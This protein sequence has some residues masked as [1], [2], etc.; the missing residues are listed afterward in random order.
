MNALIAVSGRAAYLGRG[1][2]V[3]IKK[4]VQDICSA[5]GDE[6]CSLDVQYF[7]TQSRPSEALGLFKEGYNNGVRVFIGLV[8]S[9]EA[10][11]VA[12]YAATNAPDAVIISPSSTATELCNYKQLYRLTMDDR[13]F[14]EALYDMSLEM[15]T[16]FKITNPLPVYILHLDDLHGQGLA[17]DIEDIFQK[18]NADFDSLHT[19]SYQNQQT[20][21]EALS[22]LSTAT[23][24]AQYAIIVLSGLQLDVKFIFDELKLTK[25]FHHLKSFPWVLSDTIALSDIEAPFD[26][27]A[28]YG[29]TYRGALD[30]CTS[31][32]ALSKLKKY[33]H[34]KG[35]PPM[36]QPLLA[37]DAVTVV[38]Q[39]A[40]GDHK[41]RFQFEEHAAYQ[42]ITGA[43]DFSSCHER[44]SGEYS[45]SLKKSKD[46]LELAVLA[47]DWIFLTQYKISAQES[48]QEEF[49]LHRK[50]SAAVSYSRFARSV[51]PMMRATMAE[52]IKKTNKVDITSTASAVAAIFRKELVETLQSSDSVDCQSSARIVVSTRD[53]ASN[54]VINS[55]SYS[56]ETFPEVLSI[57]AQYGFILDGS[58]MTNTEEKIQVVQVCP[59]ADIA[60]TELTCTVK[61]SQTS[62]NAMAAEFKAS[63]GI[64]IGAGLCFTGAACCFIF[65]WFAAPACAGW[66]AGCGAIMA[67][68]AATSSAGK[69]VC[70][71]LFRQGHMSPELMLADMNFA[72]TYTQ[73]HPVIRKGYDILGP[74]V[75]SW[76][77]DS[78]TVTQ[79]AKYFAIPWAEEMA[80]LSGYRDE[81]NEFG[82]WVMTVGSIVC[83]IVG[84]VYTY[85]YT[86]GK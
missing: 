26:D 52:D 15:A 44:A 32:K 39:A 74:M 70:T 66:G 7:D 37:Y 20:A 40:A 29:L 57:P 67:S 53:D 63:T 18:E 8:T 16:K 17:S 9:S 51:N 83:G 35:I 73:E 10:K 14:G 13:G 68:G 55:T 31:Q 65:A 11:A 54:E 72:L 34:D 79:I 85:S 71:E 25:E 47:K 75:A 36:V 38:Y 2:E 82:E 45:L 3:A 69:Y 50:T 24:N 33:L 19:I 46:S 49:P 27:M 81:G 58:C 60:G 21:I 4:A 12:E 80:Y 48:S 59:S 22:Q 61:T 76:M 64:F 43:I 23:A 56:L 78:E 41:L 1:I 77:K 5:E 28:L 42:G 84:G 30:G 62:T 86:I 6:S